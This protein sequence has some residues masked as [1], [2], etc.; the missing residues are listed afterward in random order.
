MLLLRPQK[1]SQRS[2][3]HCL[4]RMIM[5]NLWK[6]RQ[7][8]KKRF[9]SLY[10]L[11]HNRW[12]QRSQREHQRPKNLL[13]K[14]KLQASLWQ[15]SRLLASHKKLKRE[16]IRMS[17]FSQSTSAM[18]NSNSSRP[19]KLNS[20]KCSFLIQLLAPLR[21]HKQQLSIKMTSSSRN[22]SRALKVCGIVKLKWSTWLVN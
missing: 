20:F 2:S 9:C 12:L 5:A 16:S 21:P 15:W 18:I 8:S 11:S 19:L 22:K 6:T 14:H 7:S 1:S 4:I 17:Q 13:E 10:S 3:T